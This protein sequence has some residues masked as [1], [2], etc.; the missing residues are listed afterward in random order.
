M[1]EN[2][3]IIYIY[4]YHL[5]HHGLSSFEVD[6]DTLDPSWAMRAYRPISNP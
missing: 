5:K 3:I 2:N 6:I 1:S 4:I